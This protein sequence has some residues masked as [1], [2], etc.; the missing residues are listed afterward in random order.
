MIIL[1]VLGT[2][3][4][5][6]AEDA[7][8]SSLAATIINGTLAEANNQTFLPN[9]IQVQI[10]QNCPET[11]PVLAQWMYDEWHSYNKTLTLEKAKD[12][13]NK[14][15]TDAPI[16]FAIVALKEG[17]PIGMMALKMVGEPEFA[18]LSDN[19]PWLSSFYVIP[20]ERNK[21]LGQKLANTLI[22]IAQ[23]LG[24]AKVHFYTSNPNNVPRYLKRG[25]KIVEK[26]PFCGHT[27]TI[28]DMDLRRD[29][30]FNTLNSKETIE[31]LKGKEVIPYLEKLAGLR[32]AFY[33]NYPYLYEGNLSDEMAY[34]SMYSNS[35]NS[36]L[37]IAKKEEEIVGIASGLPMLESKEENKRLYAEKQI[38]GEHVFYLGEVVLSQEYQNTDV[39]ERIY[40][41]FEKAVIDL[42]KY[43]TIAVCEIERDPQDPKKPI[44]T[45]SSEIQW[46]NRGFFKQPELYTMD[47]WKDVGDLEKSN[48]ALVFWNKVILE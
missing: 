34:L 30:F 41:Q 19:N 25:A 21:G 45:F 29:G 33:R 32:I 6:F 8:P 15:L 42:Q 38:P 7:K 23:R 22:T 9:S 17:R 47:A 46:E 39:Q 35:E 26:R 1:F 16:P 5:S 40:Q 18:D 27:V 4:M 20:T 10:L 24:Y 13:F 37:A 12:G 2:C 3:S 43:H 44:S 36:L 48:H 14:Y 31:V 11:I 28:M